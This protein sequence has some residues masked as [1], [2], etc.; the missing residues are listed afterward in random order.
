MLPVASGGGTIA[1]MAE[2]RQSRKRRIPKLS[3][4]PEPGLGRYY[5]SYRDPAGKPRRKRFSKDRTESELAYHRWVVENYDQAA[6]IIAPDGDL[7]KG[8]INQSLPAIANAYIQHEKRRVRPEGARRAKGTI[9]LRVFDDN[10]RQVISILQWCKRRY[11]T[12]L[13]RTPFDQ[14]VTATDYESMMLSFVTR[15]SDSQVNKH[16]Q[17]F[18]EIVRFGRRDPFGIGLPFG[19]E[20]VR[21]FGGTELRKRRSIPTVKMIQEIL[22]TAT[23]R[24]RLWIWMGLG[25]GFGNDDLA[26]ARVVH[27]DADSYDMRRGKT[28]FPRY[29]V[30]R[31]FVWLHLRE[32][33]K[34]N[35]RAAEEL[36]F[37][38]KT[39][40]PL[41][42]VTA[43][44]KDEMVNGTS[45]R[46][47]A[48]TPFKR[49]DSMA[50]AWRKLKMRAGVEDWREGFYVWRHLGAT[51]YASMSGTG[52]AQ[53]RTYLG[54]GKSNAADEYLKP[55]TPETKQV[56]E[57]INQML[58]SDDLD[59]WKN[60]PKNRSVKEL[61]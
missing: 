30:M 50:Q 32:Y 14:L 28:G 35:P 20:D 46:G 4:K 39:G 3:D 53:L 8:S 41:V 45:T 59:A 24:E 19:S 7:G 11:A 44:S 23:A 26:R 43:K 16:R 9:S 5:A 47:P 10:R 60:K 15:L 54:H 13:G 2:Q 37:V 31:P 52:I 29:G 51:A 61:P 48:K 27:F 6:V 22:K 57:W 18:W 25:L 1:L 49:C 58:D 17:R 56:V 12:R 40:R 42:W 38:T 21:K 55:L 33:L 34:S 36:L